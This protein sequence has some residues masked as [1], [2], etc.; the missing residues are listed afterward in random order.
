MVLGIGSTQHLVHTSC[1]LGDTIALASLGHD[2]SYSRGGPSNSKSHPKCEHCS[3]LEH[4][5]DRCWKV[6]G[7]PLYSINATKFDLSTIIHITPSP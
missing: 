3:Q 2:Q 4:T 6:H 5:I 1:T 7:K